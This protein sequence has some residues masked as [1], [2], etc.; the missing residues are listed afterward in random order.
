MRETSELLS[1]PLLASLFSVCVYLSFFSFS[2]LK[3]HCIRLPSLA[4]GKYRAGGQ[5]ER[6]GKEGV[7]VVGNFGFREFN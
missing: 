1:L 4:G 6:G 5:G 2:L 7:V 3:P